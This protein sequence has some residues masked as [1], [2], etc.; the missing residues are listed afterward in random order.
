MLIMKFSMR[1]C[2]ATDTHQFAEGSRSILA[3]IKVLFT[4]KQ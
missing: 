2:Q 1:N 3:N 4:P